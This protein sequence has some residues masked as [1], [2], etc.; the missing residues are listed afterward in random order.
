MDK[1]L[2]NYLVLSG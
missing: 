2:G 1:M